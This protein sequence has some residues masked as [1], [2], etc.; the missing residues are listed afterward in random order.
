MN[1]Q[2]VAFL[3]MF[4]LVLML[5]VYY[6]TLPMDLSLSGDPVVAKTETDPLTDV[7]NAKKEAREQQKQ[8]LTQVIADGSS[9]VIEKSDAMEQLAFL[10]AA[11]EEEERYEQYLK[12]WG[13]EHAC[14]TL[15]DGVMR[16]VIHQPEDD[17][18]QVSSIM[19]KLLETSEYRYMPEIEFQ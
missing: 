19:K 14:V 6:V 7:R 4:S 11:Q 15:Q 1:R 16:V 3:T 9:S 10:Q 13:Y 5:A 17:H 12:D 2:A 8:Q 18:T